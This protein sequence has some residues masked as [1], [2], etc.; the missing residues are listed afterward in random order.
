M[1]AGDVVTPDEKQRLRESHV[2]TWRTPEYDNLI[3]A[4][5]TISQRPRRK[6]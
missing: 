3:K 6:K 2:S 1:G 4:A 5:V